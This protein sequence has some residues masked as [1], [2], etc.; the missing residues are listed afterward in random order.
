[1]MQK[2]RLNASIINPGIFVGH[3]AN[4]LL[5]KEEKYSLY[6]F[7]ALL[8][9]RLLDFVFKT[10]SRTNHIP[11]GEIKKLP[12]ASIDLA[13]DMDVYEAIINLSKEILNFRMNENQGRLES[14]KLEEFSALEDR[15]DSMIFELYGLSD[16]E[17]LYVD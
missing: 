4:Y 9:S 17:I 1:M 7:L 6:Y 12:I 13:K 2:R 10:F 5:L 11:A 14:S 15:M 16:V 8:N 3:T